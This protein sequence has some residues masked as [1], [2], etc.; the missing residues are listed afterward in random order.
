MKQWAFNLAVAWTQGWNAFWGGNPDQT[1]SGRSWEARS[2]GKLW[3]YI[4]VAVIDTLFFWQEDHCR[5][6]FLRDES[7]KTYG[8]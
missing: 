1:F 4:A 3:G 5:M 6:S 8:Q 2:E 7:E